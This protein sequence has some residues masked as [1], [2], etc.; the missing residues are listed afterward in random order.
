MTYQIW[1]NELG[2][3]DA[4]NLIATG[5][6]VPYWDDE[7]PLTLQYQAWL[8][9]HPDF[10]VSDHEPEPLPSQPDWEQFRAM[11]LSHSAYFRIIGSNPQNQILNAPLTWSL[12]EV[13]RNPSILPDVANIW[14]AIAYNAA[15][16]T[17]E[18]Q[19]L[20]AIATSCNMPFRLDESGFMLIS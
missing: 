3:V 12:G 2:Q 8:Q 4:I 10:D 1:R 14:G 20:N 5:E 9:D 17:A 18:I 11:V 7:H 16:T 15:P 13:G 19:Q 6:V